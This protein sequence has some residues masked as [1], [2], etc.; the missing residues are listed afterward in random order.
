MPAATVDDTTW[1]SPPATTEPAE[2][3]SAQTP[4]GPLT[5][6]AQG[7]RA[8]VAASKAARW[9]R[10]FCPVTLLPVTM[11]KCPPA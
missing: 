7:S 10:M 3:D 9:W 2:A 5:V 11:S 4:W 1:K 6:G 8:P